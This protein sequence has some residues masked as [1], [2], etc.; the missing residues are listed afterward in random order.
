MA[1]LRFE[2]IS[3]SHS[4]STSFFDQKVS[5]QLEV[6]NSSCVSSLMKPEADTVRR[7]LNQAQSKILSYLTFVAS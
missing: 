4:C 7:Y 5:N 6:L 2:L 3:E 1:H